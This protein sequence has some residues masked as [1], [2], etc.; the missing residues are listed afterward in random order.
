MR[1]SLRRWLLVVLLGVG[2]FGT[3]YGPVIAQDL[4]RKESDFI[5]RDFNF[6]SGEV[7]P[8]LRLHYVTLGT[9]KR[10]AAG[11][12]TNAV[13]LLHGTGGSG[14]A[15][16]NN[17]ASQLFGEGQILDAGKYYLIVPDAI[18]H[19]ASSKPSDGLRAKFPHYGY[20]DMVEGQHRLVTEGLGVDHLRL[21]LGGSMGGMHTWMWGGKYPDMMDALMPTACLPT[22]I[23]GHNFLFRNVITSAIRNDPEWNGGAYEKQPTHWVDALPLWNFM[24]N[25]RARLYAAAPNNAK[26]K[27]LFDTIADNGRKNID[28]NDFLY[29]LDSSF[30][31]DPEPGLGKIKA[32][33]LTVNFA[34]DLINAVETGV[35][36]R[37]VAK[38]PNARSV[39]MPANDHSYGH[40]NH[41]H[42]EIWKPH[43]VELL[44]SLP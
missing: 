3:P 29:A 34:D 7:L 26:S 5:V 15:I 18:G 1:F 40:F 25:S 44:T 41:V 36:E 9:P 35:L 13:L 43:L 11:H 6:Q 42:P 27:E 31:Y 39:I 21:V 30:D 33:I 19:G 20:T 12:V 4:T 37:A 28:A 8:E 22:Q 32:H 24:L 16:L 14:K 10:D 17:Y 38:I 2:A 23:A